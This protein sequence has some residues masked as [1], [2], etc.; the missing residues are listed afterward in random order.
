[1]TST[2]KGSQR[3]GEPSGFDEHSRLIAATPAGVVTHTTSYDY[4]TVTCIFT[5][6]HGVV[7]QRRSLSERT[8]KT[9][10]KQMLRHRFK[11]CSEPRYCLIAAL[12]AP[13]RAPA[14]LLPPSKSR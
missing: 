3:T 4:A 10:P 5:G 8:K 12:P 9:V 11:I 6:S 13:V 2:L 7:H 14:T 1:M